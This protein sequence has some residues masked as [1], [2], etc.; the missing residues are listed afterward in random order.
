MLLLGLRVFGFVF[1]LNWL[2]W[3]MARR[4]FHY[5]FPSWVYSHNKKPTTSLEIVY[6]N[7]TYTMF[8]ISVCHDYPCCL[9]G[10]NTVNVVPLRGQGRYNVTTVHTHRPEGKASNL[11]NSHSS[12]ASLRCLFSLGLPDPSTI[13]IP[14]I[15]SISKSDK[16]W[17]KVIDSLIR[18]AIPY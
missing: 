2:Q 1:V 3:E 10:G 9:C 11:P 7:D 15:F 6:N 16:L 12:Q 5:F 14:A 18:D 17:I 4:W 8:T 13:S